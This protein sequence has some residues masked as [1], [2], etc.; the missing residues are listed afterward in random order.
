MGPASLLLAASQLEGCFSLQ[1]T[2]VTMV[3]VYHKGLEKFMC[4]LS[5]PCE[6]L[7]TFFE[8]TARRFGHPSKKEN[9]RCGNQHTCEIVGGNRSVWQQGIGWEYCCTPVDAVSLC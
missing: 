2:E 6:S 8:V 3:L 4:P 5:C 7:G 1:E 9:A